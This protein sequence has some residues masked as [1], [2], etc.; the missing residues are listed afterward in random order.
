MTLKKSAKCERPD[1]K[2]MLMSRDFKSE[3]KCFKKSKIA[4][5]TA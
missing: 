3:S 5:I 2:S 1:F 4:L